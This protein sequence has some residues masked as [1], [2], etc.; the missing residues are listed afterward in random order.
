QILKTGRPYADLGAGFYAS[1]ETTQARQD[2]LIRQLR[3]L[4]PGCRITITPRRPPDH[5]AAPAAE[6]ITRHP[7][8]TKL[9]PATSQGFAAARP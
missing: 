1:R 8:A 2:Y 7:P 9:T 4:N 6:P 5:P 3:K